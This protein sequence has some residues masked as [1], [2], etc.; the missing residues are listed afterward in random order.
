MSTFL[1]CLAIVAA[2][3]LA[4]LFADADLAP[5]PLRPNTVRRKVC[6]LTQ[7]TTAAPPRVCR[8]RQWDA[9]A[10][11]SR[12]ASMRNAWRSRIRSRHQFPGRVAAAAA[13][14]ADGRTLSA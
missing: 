12:L 5:P 4:A 14:D 3:V 9:A 13:S 8:P 2:V 1:R 6:C 7:Q 10:G 11:R